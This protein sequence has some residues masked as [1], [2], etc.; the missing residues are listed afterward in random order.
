L[1][2]GRD[3][4]AAEIKARTGA[5]SGGARYRGAG[6]TTP[7]TDSLDAS[8]ADVLQEPAR[9]SQVAPLPNVLSE[10]TWDLFRILLR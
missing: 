7:V 9:G 2:E 4:L 10:D 3:T 8:A 1:L 5:L 6:D